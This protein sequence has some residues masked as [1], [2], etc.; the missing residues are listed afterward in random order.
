MPAMKQVKLAPASR[1]TAPKPGA[2]AALPALPDEE[3]SDK[4]EQRRRRILDATLA[5]YVAYGWGGTNMSVISRHVRMTRGMIQ[6]YFPTFD[7]VLRASVAHLNNEWRKKYFSY[8]EQERGAP[9]RLGVGVNALW[10]LMRDPLHV[11]KQE[12]VAAARSNAELRAVME[13]EAGFDE[14]ASLEMA[15]QAY[16]DLAHKDERAFRRALD[17]TVVF[18]EG[19]SRHSFGGDAEARCEVLLG[20]LKSYLDGYW[21]S[22]GIELSPH[23]PAVA[24]VPVPAQIQAAAPAPVRLDDRDRDRALA[25]ILKAAAILSDRPDTAE[26]D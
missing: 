12:I 25:F 26:R 8:I 2:K 21:H 7:D 1:K 16:P 6:Y 22:L 11:A 10:R 9:D 18:L 19:L 17:F 15:K 23:E 14:A 3:T 24:A 5:C 20:M 4:S 13:K